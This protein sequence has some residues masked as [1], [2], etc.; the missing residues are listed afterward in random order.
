M[1]DR[2]SMRGTKVEMASDPY[3]PPVDRAFGATRL[4]GTRMR[5]CT[6]AH[7]LACYA[8]VG[9]G[10]PIAMVKPAASAAMGLRRHGPA[11]EAHGRVAP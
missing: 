10:R 4:S 6:G 5:L 2:R 7:I 9:A 11:G 3:G 1:Y 8:K